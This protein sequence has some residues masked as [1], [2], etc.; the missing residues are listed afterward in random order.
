MFQFFVAFLALLL[1]TRS[2]P[3]LLYHTARISLSI[4]QCLYRFTFYRIDHYRS[5]LNDHF[6]FGVGFYF[7]IYFTNIFF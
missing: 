7:Y 6:T 5:F 3:D 2:I 1:L 4:T